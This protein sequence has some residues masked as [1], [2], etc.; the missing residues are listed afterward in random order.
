MRK[1]SEPSNSAY[2]HLL[3]HEMSTITPH[4]NEALYM[5][6]RYVAIPATS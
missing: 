1:G 5:I 2:W 3:E 6:F 4:L